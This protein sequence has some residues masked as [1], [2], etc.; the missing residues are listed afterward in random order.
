MFKR[1]AMILNYCKTIELKEKQ[2]LRNL[3]TRNKDQI[4]IR[5]IQKRYTQFNLN[6]SKCT[7]KLCSNNATHW[8]TRQNA[9]YCQSDM[10]CEYHAKIWMQVKNLISQA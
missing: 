3:T 7:V 2:S 1:N 4:K 10:V 8:L 6:I 9:E 5:E